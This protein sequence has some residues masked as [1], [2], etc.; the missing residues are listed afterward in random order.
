MYGRKINMDSE[1]LLLEQA[2]LYI[3]LSGDPCADPERIERE[4][5][6]LKDMVIVEIYFMKAV[7][8]II[9]N[10]EMSGFILFVEKDLRAMIDAFDPERSCMLAF[11]RHCM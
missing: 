8:A 1:E 4:F 9:T 6:K 7:R 5:M 2:R 3:G 10:D 11:L